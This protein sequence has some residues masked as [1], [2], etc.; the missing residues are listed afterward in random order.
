MHAIYCTYCRFVS[1]FLR[2]QGIDSSQVTIRNGVVTD[3]EGVIARA[4]RRITTTYIP[5]NK[6]VLSTLAFVPPR[7]LLAAFNLSLIGLVEPST[8]DA[9][10]EVVSMAL[11]LKEVVFSIKCQELLPMRHCSRIGIVRAIDL[12]T[13]Q[14]LVIFPS[15][16]TEG[17][18]FQSLRDNCHLIRSNI[19]VPIQLQYVANDV[20]YPYLTSE[21][22]GQGNRIMKAR[23]NVKRKWHA[24]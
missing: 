16:S 14:L 11:K 18:P 24:Q 1:Y 2:H 23:T 22:E 8:E 3:N 15:E 17:K 19:P 10:N 9:A 7:L 4:L 13:Q 5:F 6:A 12:Q 21:M 20:S